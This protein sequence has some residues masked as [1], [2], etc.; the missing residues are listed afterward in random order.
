LQ[1]IRKSLL[2]LQA[3]TTADLAQQGVSCS[4][5]SNLSKIESA[6]IFKSQNHGFFSDSRILSKKK[7]SAQSA[8]K[9][10]CNGSA[11]M[12]SKQ[13]PCRLHAAIFPSIAAVSVK[14]PKL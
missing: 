6:G 4:L 5:N 8:E 14:N 10:I 12:T 3:K 9:H 2:P 1:H 13:E 7:L 11:E